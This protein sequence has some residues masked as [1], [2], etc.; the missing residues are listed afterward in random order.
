MT[1]PEHCKRKPVTQEYQPWPKPRQQRRTL[2]PGTLLPQSSTHRVHGGCH[3][4]CAVNCE[5]EEV[6]EQSYTERSIG[7]F[8][9]GDELMQLPHWEKFKHHGA[10]LT[11]TNTKY[12]K[13][14]GTLLRSTMNCNYWWKKCSI[15]FKFEKNSHLQIK[16]IIDKGNHLVLKP[17]VKGTGLSCL[18]RKFALDHVALFGQNKMSKQ[19]TFQGRTFTIFFCDLTTN[20]NASQKVPPSILTAITG[21]TAASA[22]P[23][24]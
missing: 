18:R 20:V 19:T 9:Q 10:F 13:A 4:L 23:F 15:V 24:V 12:R 2:R 5:K 17:M 11:E 3:I 14:G 6:Y 8:I 16:L 21:R 1:D 7:N 22:F